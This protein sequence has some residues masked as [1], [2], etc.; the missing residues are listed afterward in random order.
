MTQNLL[1]EREEE[2]HATV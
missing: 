2:G 1:A